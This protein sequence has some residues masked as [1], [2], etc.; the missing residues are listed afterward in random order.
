MV[1]LLS[2]MQLRAWA[3]NEKECD[4]DGDLGYAWWCGGVSIWH[5]AKEKEGN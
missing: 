2:K 3:D 5:K 1:E 4:M